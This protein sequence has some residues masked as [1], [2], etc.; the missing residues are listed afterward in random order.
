MLIL[1]NFENDHI[2]IIW[3]RGPF[4]E[5]LLN[6]PE[7]Q[8]GA[9]PFGTALVAAL[10]LRPLGGYWPGIALAAGFYLSA[11]AMGVLQLEPTRSTNK[12]LLLGLAALVLGI[13]FDAVMRRSSGA[14]ADP[15]K[16]PFNHRVLVLAL[17]AGAAAL[18]LILAVLGR[19]QG[20]D[21]WL[22]GVGSF[23]YAA[24][25]VFWL[26]ALRDDPLRAS[27]A[28]W[29][30]ALTTAACVILGASALLGQLAIGLGAA[31]GAFCLLVIFM[32]ALKTGALFVLPT[33]VLAALIAVAGVIF[34]KT[35]WYSLI[36]LALVPLAVRLPVPNA[37][38]RLGQ[39]VVFA[40][41]AL[42]G[43]VAAALLVWWQSA[44]DSAYY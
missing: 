28:S 24:W 8:S 23:F 9:I 40:V 17:L 12:V 42:P 27:S 36:L 26:L 39:A 14:S 32:P 35:P 6:L 2:R 5:N 10:L 31:A 37:W 21:F 25:L 15:V 13:L 11:Y 30:L 33:A 22:T 38:P 41:Y 44:S 18:W 43:G 4:L 19:Q 34:A 20:M 16:N 1:G 7:I 29:A 3:V